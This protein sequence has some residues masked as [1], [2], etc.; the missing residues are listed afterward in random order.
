MA[1]E[2]KRR[3]PVIVAAVVVL[4]GSAILWWDLVR[5]GFT[6]GGV[7]VP[8]LFTVLGVFWL[9]VGFRAPDG[10]DAAGEVEDTEA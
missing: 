6:M 10:A 7:L 4:I 1:V 8:A 3:T 5:E 9:A 2:T